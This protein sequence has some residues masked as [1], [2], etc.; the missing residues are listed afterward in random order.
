MNKLGFLYF[1][2]VEVWGQDDSVGALMRAVSCLY[3]AIFWLHF[4]YDR[5]E[6]MYLPRVSGKSVN[7]FYEGYTSM[8]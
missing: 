6:K 8:A 4:S 1:W 7:P 3:T 2:T 5:R